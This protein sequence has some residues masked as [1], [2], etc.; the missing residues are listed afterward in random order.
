VN[1]NWVGKTSD[2]T[3]EEIATTI[4]TTQLNPPTHTG[5]KKNSFYFIGAGGFTKNDICR[6]YCGALSCF[7]YFCP[8]ILSSY[9]KV[10]T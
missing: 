9:S 3:N 5:R 7:A 10:L 1:L 4:L 8:A 2:F 6:N